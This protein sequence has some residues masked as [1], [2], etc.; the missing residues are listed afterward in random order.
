MKQSA[1]S[2]FLHNLCVPTMINILEE[3]FVPDHGGFLS[4]NASLNLSKEQLDNFAT[5]VLLE[6]RFDIERLAGSDPAAANTHNKEQ[7]VWDC[8]KGLKAVVYYRIAHHLLD[9]ENNCL[10]PIRS[11]FDSEE[12][13]EVIKDYMRLQARKISERAA[14]ETTIEI[15]PSAQIGKGFVID[16]GVGT[17]VASEGATFSTVIGE[18]CVIGDNCTLLNS[19]LLGASVINEASSEKEGIAVGKRHPTLGN[20]VT[21]CAGARILGNITIGDDVT[22]GPCCVITNDIPSGYNVTIVN[23]LQFSRPS[24]INGYGEQGAKPTIHGLTLDTNGYLKLFGAN[25]SLCN[26]SIVTQ[27]KGVE[28]EVFSLQVETIDIRE[29]SITFS[30]KRDTSKDQ[31][32]VSTYSLRITTSSYEYILSNPQVLKQY[33]GRPI[34]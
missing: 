31:K 22:I 28:G 10:M 1:E 4:S 19:V 13:N 23:Q 11:A 5:D 18:T 2:Q 33:I 8:Y 25:L 24:S 15:N 27:D 21:V 9:F 32:Q 17:R 7:Y 20:N 16:H 30:V 34:I 12:D 14:T 26:L 29:D 6:V 3:T